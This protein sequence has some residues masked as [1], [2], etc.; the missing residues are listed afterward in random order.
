MA[1]ITR[2]RYAALMTRA[3]ET[4]A[5]GVLPF[6]I[7]PWPVLARRSRSP[8]FS[9]KLV[10]RRRT[11]FL[12][13]DPGGLLRPMAFAKFSSTRAQWRA[14]FFPGSLQPCG[15]LKPRVRGASRRGESPPGKDNG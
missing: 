9:G 2:W 13:R 7:S 6:R 3:S 1:A 8:R 5:I 15:A 14:L 12:G 11:Y 4:G 10:R